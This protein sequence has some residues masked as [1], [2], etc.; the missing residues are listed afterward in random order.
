MS[1]PLVFVDMDIEIEEEG[2][3]K[4]KHT[5]DKELGESYRIVRHNF[6]D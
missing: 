4:G 2:L 3:L 1:D 5:S 6:F